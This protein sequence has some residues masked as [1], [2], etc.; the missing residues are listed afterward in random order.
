MKIEEKIQELQFVEQN[1]QNVL[2]QKQQFQTELIEIDNALKEL[3]K[4]PKETYKIIGNIM[5]ATDRKE[6]KSDLESK[7]D[8]I[9]I[10]IKNI[11][12]QEIN[13]KE[14]TNKLQKEV[15]PKLKK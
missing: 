7:K 6:L 5:I 1:M 10:R 9:A 8:I 4:N 11:E 13:L 2:M 15:I 3:S 14:K 12:K